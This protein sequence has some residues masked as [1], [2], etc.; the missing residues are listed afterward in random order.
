MNN[1]HCLSV[2]E[3]YDEVGSNSNG[4]NSELVKE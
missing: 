2:E 4:L 3:I 1:W